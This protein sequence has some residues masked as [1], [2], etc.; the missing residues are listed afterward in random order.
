MPRQMLH[1]RQRG[2]A[3]YECESVVGGGRDGG[4]TRSRRS[5]SDTI[6]VPCHAERVN[7]PMSLADAP[8]A[9]THIAFEQPMPVKHLVPH[10]KRDVSLTSGAL[11]QIGCLTVV[12]C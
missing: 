3:S 8:N 6:C 11:K 1:W 7:P 5:A 12:V 9:I 4:L 10:V 2:D